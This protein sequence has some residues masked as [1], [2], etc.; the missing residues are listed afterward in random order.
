MK[1]HQAFPVVPE[2]FAKGS[3][4]MAKI[5]GEVGAVAWSPSLGSGYAAILQS[6]I[7]ERLDLSQL[8]QTITCE[9]ASELKE[10]AKPHY[11]LYSSRDHPLWLALEAKE[12]LIYTKE[13]ILMYRVT[14]LDCIR[15]KGLNA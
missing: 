4:L 11:V 14:D 8:G 3:T 15:A 1:E 10:Q 2:I 12:R 9:E 5:A 7:S 13:R 6:E